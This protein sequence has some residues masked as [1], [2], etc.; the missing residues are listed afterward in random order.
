MPDREV[1]KAQ[2]SEVCFFCGKEPSDE[3]SAYLYPMC[4]VLQIKGTDF[5]RISAIVGL[6]GAVGG[7]V[8]GKRGLYRKRIVEVPRC[9]GCK[10]IG[11]S[12]STWEAETVDKG[13]FYGGGVGFVL[14]LL[15]VLVAKIPMPDA[16]YVLFGGCIFGF[17]I[18][19]Y[20]GKQK[21]W[22]VRN[23]LGEASEQEKKA[24]EFPRIKLMLEE[25]WQL[26]EEP[27]EPAGVQFFEV[28]PE[29]ELEVMNALNNT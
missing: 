18:G 4:Q 3:E 14:G 25:G 2:K 28:P 27:T 16:L 13:E 22:L 6:V 7:F 8:P 17:L 5:W 10:V 15:L 29:K 1:V 11:D 24:S 9:S 20:V 21:T 26:G 19:R 12:V 23:A